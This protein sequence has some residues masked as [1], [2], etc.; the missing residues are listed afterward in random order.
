MNEVSAWVRTGILLL[1][2]S[3]TYLILEKQITKIEK[4]VQTA[5]TILEEGVCE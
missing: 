2:I 4:D 5:V 1:A 3:L